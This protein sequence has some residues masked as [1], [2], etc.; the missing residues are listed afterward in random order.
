MVEREGSAGPALQLLGT[1]LS[2]YLDVLVDAPHRDA[3]RDAVGEWTSRAASDGWSLD[4][5]QLPAGSPLIDAPLADGIIS[6]IDPHEPCPVLALE[7]DG[8]AARPSIKKSMANNV[9]YY[10]RRSRAAGDLVFETAT[11]DTCAGLLD[12]VFRLHAMRRSA[13]RGG[14]LRDPRVAALHRRVAPALAARGMLALH[15]ARLDGRAVAGM[16]GFRDRS[17]VYLYMCGLDPSCGDISP[18][19]LC[20]DYMITCAWRAGARAV[21]FLRGRER[22]KYLWGA[23]DR[24]TFRRQ[25]AA[26]AAASRAC[27]SRA[28]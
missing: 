8:R 23:V 10:T 19:T 27:S 13:E 16:Y 1:G 18:G 3:V 4:W 7:G 24:G 26:P 25:I 17:R 21:E 11:A 14:V 15:V 22:Y 20:I 12:E 2:D 5:Q 6:R 28:S 9:A